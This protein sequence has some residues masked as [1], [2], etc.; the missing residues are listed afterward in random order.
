MFLSSRK[1]RTKLVSKHQSAFAIRASHGCLTFPVF[2]SPAW[3]SSCLLCCIIRILSDLATPFRNEA[4]HKK[5][6]L[7]GKKTENMAG[8][9]E[10]DS[11]RSNRSF[12]GPPAVVTANTA[13][14]V[15]FWK[16]GAKRG[17][18]QLLVAEKLFGQVVSRRKEKEARRGNWGVASPSDEMDLFLSSLAFSF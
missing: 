2:I 6:N 5:I 13:I 4:G 10:R 17:K 7:K 12:P 18:E 16:A 3:Y 14:G 11:H 1:L 15:S 8:E 9:A